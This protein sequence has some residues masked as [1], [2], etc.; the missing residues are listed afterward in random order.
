MLFNKNAVVRD[1]AIARLLYMLLSQPES[2]QYLPKINQITDVIPNHICMLNLP[3]DLKKNIVVNVYRESPIYP[4]LELLSSDTE[5]EPSVRKATF[6]QLNIMAQDPKLN[7]IIHDENG[8]F[9]V[10]NALQNALK[11]SLFIYCKMYYYFYC[12]S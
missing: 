5:I 3:I 11:V 8:L 12:Q 6:L 2:D 9:L 1:E 10:L 7:D 4:L